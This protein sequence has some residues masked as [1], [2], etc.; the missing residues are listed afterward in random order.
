MR[1]IF[2]KSICAIIIAIVFV[3][4]SNSQTFE[5]TD[6]ILPNDWSERRIQR[7]RE[8]VIGVE[9]NL[10]LSDNEV[11]LTY[12]PNNGDTEVFILKQIDY[13]LYRYE[14]DYSVVDLELNNIMGYTASCKFSK[15]KTGYRT[16]MIFNWTMV[17]ERK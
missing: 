12:T 11:K 7:A 5:V 13:D 14:D 6:I 9:V 15:Y 17:L 3:G 8:S 16:S 4:C 1:I 2:L 10:L